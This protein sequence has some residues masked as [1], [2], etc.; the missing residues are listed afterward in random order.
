MVTNKILQIAGN[1]N[2]AWHNWK[3]TAPVIQQHI[4]KNSHFSVH[5]TEDIEDF[6]RLNL[7]DY[8]AIILN[9]TNWEA[10]GLSDTS[11]NKFLEYLNNGGNLYIHHFS[12][13]AFHHSLPKASE[14]DW[15]EFR[16]ICRRVWDHSSDS[17]HD[18]YQ[19]FQVHTTELDHPITQGLESFTI[20]DELYFNQKGTESIEPLIYAVSKISNKKEPLAWA[21]QYGK[22]KVFQNLLGHSGES[23]N[24]KGF[25]TILI[26]AIKWLTN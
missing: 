1:E 15:P 8:R 22:A 18:S 7:S 13:G 2:H 11:K 6:S 20:K 26:N 9:Y 16:I 10:Q 21:Y 5:T 12:N 14:S 19:E 17:K 24:S 4:E 23:V 25:E 3:D